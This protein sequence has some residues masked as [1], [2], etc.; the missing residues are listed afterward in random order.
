MPPCPLWDRGSPLCPQP[1]LNGGTRRVGKHQGKPQL[2]LSS[3]N[4]SGLLRHTNQAAFFQQRFQEGNAVT[5]WKISAKDKGSKSE[6]RFRE[7]AP[8]SP[9]ALRPQPPRPPGASPCPR[10]P[11]PTSVRPSWPSCRPSGPALPELTGSAALFHPLTPPSSLFL[12]CKRTCES[13]RR[14]SE[15]AHNSAAG[16]FLPLPGSWS[17]I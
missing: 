17:G 1:A 3:A 2:G 14:E 13:C 12:C 8:R 5:A 7:P 6:V 16:L 10:L 9:A 4:Y 15:I 11:S